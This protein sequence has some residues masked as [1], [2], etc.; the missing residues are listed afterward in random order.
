VVGSRG[1]AATTLN[2]LL[3][4]LVPDQA[5]RRLRLTDAGNPD[6]VYADLDGS[7]NDM[8][9]TGGPNAPIW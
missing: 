7:R 2:E 1:Y 9:F 6:P 5:P 4:D 3:L 8:G